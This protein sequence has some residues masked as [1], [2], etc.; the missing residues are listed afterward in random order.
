MFMKT[1]LTDT[2]K[3]KYST[4]HNADFKTENMQKFS[5]LNQITYPYRNPFDRIS[6]CNI[7]NMYV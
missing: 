5:E 4:F 1:V 7:T 2:K 6:S 3:S